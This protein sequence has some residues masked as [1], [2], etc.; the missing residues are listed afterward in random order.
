MVAVC[1]LFV[2]YMGVKL[3]EERIN[4]KLLMKWGKEIANDIYRM[5]CQG[6]GERTMNRTGLSRPSDFN[7]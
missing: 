7:M 6:Y 3:L 2:K 1:V 4:I 5:L